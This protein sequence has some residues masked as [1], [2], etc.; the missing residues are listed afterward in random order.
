MKKFLDSDLKKSEKKTPIFQQNLKF[1]KKS[2]QGKSKEFSIEK[3]LKS[4]KSQKNL[5]NFFI[6]SPNRQKGF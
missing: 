4:S 1:R 2:L 6:N 3:I 5:A